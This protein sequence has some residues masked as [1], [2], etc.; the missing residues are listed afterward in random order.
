MDIGKQTTMIYKSPD[1]T[2]MVNMNGT[3]LQ[4]VGNDFSS[5]LSEIGDFVDPDDVITADGFVRDVMTINGQFPG[6]TIEV[7]RDTE[8]SC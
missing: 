8:V 2:L 1:G 6:P 5:T 7:L 4:L 3:R